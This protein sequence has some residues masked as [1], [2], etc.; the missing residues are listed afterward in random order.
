MLKN[1]SHGPQYSGSP[2]AWLT[3]ESKR[4]TCIYS[5]VQAE[6]VVDND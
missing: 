1:V 6:A 2:L 3:H 4:P 5:S